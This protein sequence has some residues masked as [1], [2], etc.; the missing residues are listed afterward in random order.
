MEIVFTERNMYL[1][2]READEAA[3]ALDDALAA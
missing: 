1:A 2:E 3:Y